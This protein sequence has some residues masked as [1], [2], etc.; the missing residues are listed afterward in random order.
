[1]NAIPDGKVVTCGAS[2]IQNITQFTV[3]SA[4][5]EMG[6]VI[7]ETFE[8]GFSSEGDPSGTIVLSIS[9]W[10]DFSVHLLQWQEILEVNYISDT[11]LDGRV[12]CFGEERLTSAWVS[13]AFSRQLA[14]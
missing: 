14:F 5:S 13:F 2:E 9:W 3:H 7:M 8:F 1:M 10:L 12:S 6:K 4:I 11:V